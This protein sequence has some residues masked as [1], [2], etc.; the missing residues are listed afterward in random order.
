MILPFESNSTISDNC[1]PSQDPFSSDNGMNTSEIQPHHGKNCTDNVSYNGSTSTSHDNI[2]SLSAKFTSALGEFSYMSCPSMH[3]CTFDT[4][5]CS[6]YS[7]CINTV[8]GYTC[9]CD[10]GYASKSII[11]PG[12]QDA[13]C[14]PQCSNCTH[15][16]C[17]EPGKCVC[18]LGWA[19]INCDIDCGCNFNSVCVNETA[20]GLCLNCQKFT[21]GQFCEQCVE[22]AYGN[23]T[24]LSVGCRPCN[25][26]NNGDPARGTCHSITGEC[27]CKNYAAGFNCEGCQEG[28]YRVGDICRAGCRYE[29]RRGAGWT[30]RFLLTEPRAGLGTNTVS[31]QRYASDT[32]CFWLIRAPAN[33]SIRL[34][35][36]SFATECSYDYLHVFDDLAPHTANILAVL[37]GVLPQ[38]AV[39]SY[40]G[41]ML[42]SMYSD[43]NYELSGIEAD[44]VIEPCPAMCSGNG[45]CLESGYCN[46]EIGWSG[47]DCSIETCP[48][49]CS[50][51]L[52][53]G[54]CDAHL[55]ACICSPGF[56]GDG[57]S[58][59]AE[60]GYWWPV[61]VVGSTKPPP[62]SGHAMTMAVTRNE[63]W[64]YG[65][66]SGRNYFNDTWVLDLASLRWKEV[67]TTMSNVSPG[68]RHMA[69]AVWYNEHL[70][71]FCGATGPGQFTNE[72]W[73]LDVQRLVW[74]HIDAKGDVPLALVGHSTALVEDIVY[75]FGG[76][77]EEVG[78]SAVLYTFNLHTYTWQTIRGSGTRPDGNFGSSLV[79]DSKRNQLI[80]FGGRRYLVPGSNAGPQRSA[81]I[82]AFELESEEWRIIVTSPHS[83]PTGSCIARSE[84][85]TGIIGDYMIVHG[86]NRFQHGSENLCH[87]DDTLLF[88]IPCG[89]W[90]SDTSRQQS[91]SQ[92][93]LRKAHRAV[94]LPTGEILI[95][96]GVAGISLN[97]A[98]IYRPRDNYCNWHTS[99]ASCEDDPLCFWNVTLSFCS[100]HF[101]KHAA[102]DNDTEGYVATYFD[103][104]MYQC[105]R[106]PACE[107]RGDA[108]LFRYDKCGSC[109][110]NQDCTFCPSSQR[111]V[112]AGS[113]ACGSEADVM[114][115]PGENGCGACAH[116]L[117]CRS[118][119]GDKS[120]TV[121]TGSC[122]ENTD[123]STII[124]DEVCAPICTQHT[125]C[126]SCTQQ[127]GCSWC[128]GL[129]LCFANAAITTELAFG[130]CFSYSGR[131]ASCPFSDCHL[132]KSCGNCL[133]LARCGWCAEPGLS[134]NGTCYLGTLAGPGLYSPNRTTSCGSV[135]NLPIDKNVSA[136]IIPWNPQDTI[137]HRTWNAFSCP[138]KDECKLGIAECSA[139]AFCINEDP[140]LIPGSR[141]Y[142]CECPLNYTLLSDGLTCQARCDL[143]G[144]ING[145]C[146][147]PD[148]CACF[149]GWYGMN[150]SSDCGCNGH[151]TCLTPNN[152]SECLDYTE[153]RQCEFCKDGFHGDPANNGTCRNCSVVC[154]GQSTSCRSTLLPESI[155]LTEPVCYNC[156]F[157]THGSYCEQCDQGYFLSPNIL[158]EARGADLHPH[159]L[160]RQSDDIFSHCIPCAC[161]GHG[162]SCDTVTGEEC[163]CNDLTMTNLDLC[164]QDQ[165]GSCYHVQ[166]G[167]C[168]RS[169]T[170]D[171]IT[172]Q[173]SGDPRNGQ[174]CFIVPSASVMLPQTLLPGEILL[175]EVIPKFTNVDVRMIAYVE[176][177]GPRVRLYVSLSSNVT[178]EHAN[179]L[180]RFAQAPIIAQDVGRQT[181]AVANHKDFNLLRD[182][183]YV[184]I[185][186]MGTQEANV[187]FAFA[188]SVVQINLVVFFA[189]FFSAFFLFSATMVGIARIHADLTER[190]TSLQEQ[191]LL[192]VILSC[193]IPQLTI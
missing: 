10:S 118:C 95:F 167:Q 99:L 193:L 101:M 35:I 151:C 184:A 139:V 18:D 77:T 153:G 124:V 71:I 111:C 152:R 125:T 92:P 2:T 162:S 129:Q 21:S 30:S 172:F 15:G 143:H 6:N 135:Y 75:I 185:H 105:Q 117:T 90:I 179:I 163:Q 161:N 170:K 5:A 27:Y 67:L 102:Y 154:N 45:I 48:L 73:H 32:S 83:C 53:Q 34:V 61:N 122:V 33:H 127:T 115:K 29:D 150:C 70:Y 145:V 60:D 84:H 46:C 31:H 98:Y 146:T 141:G 24:D 85:V 106:T 173:V 164:D 88:H 136:T 36:Q 37:D 121:G 59:T 74:S 82:M 4:D 109:I 89:K 43:V 128:E 108:F 13:P 110:S 191:V 160:L 63:L 81:T 171:F 100:P 183:F 14:Q 16:E 44:Y 25:C 176:Q 3:K 181:I 132:Q 156:T 69:T 138:D 78:L 22:G 192:E 112:P 58:E 126:S 187:A 11:R 64:V 107:A 166:C 39:V 119:V 7:T 76:M 42:I 159:E 38:T 87:S 178:M 8:N 186:N 144:C 188:Q 72:V 104:N 49:N 12:R 1:F 20:Y 80:L 157:P 19:G 66:L 50:Q 165:F 41:I 97:D 51:H 123:S 9:L 91:G 190:T 86:G 174:Q 177:P 93:L 103:T 140:R 147:K 17:V 120:C 113:N 180:P 158:R 133:S 62:R 134:G 28:F 148:V 168:I 182:R 52:G 68:G 149:Q 96:G 114:R 79:Y 56:A 65:G 116:Y 175:F 169:F 142:R 54:M 55:S 130:Q 155:E 23:A 131:Q 40:S 57:C 94:A 26:N 47:L 137:E 189:V